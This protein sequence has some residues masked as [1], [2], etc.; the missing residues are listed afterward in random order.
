MPVLATTSKNLHTIYMHGMLPL[1]VECTACGRKVLF[2]AK[3][4][5]ACKGNMKE[6][7]RLRFV[8][9]LCGSRDWQGWL[10]FSAL[11]AASFLQGQEMRSPVG[12]SRPT[13]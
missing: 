11:D 4:L 13:F 8:C 5:G 3:K 6:L 2:E 12:G 9:S 10:F 7:R 1:G